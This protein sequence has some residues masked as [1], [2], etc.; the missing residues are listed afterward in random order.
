MVASAA[1]VKMINKLLKRERAKKLPRGSG[2][3]ASSATV[4][5][6]LDVV[7]KHVS[8]DKVTAILNDLSA[9]KGNSSFMTTIKMLIEAWRKRGNSL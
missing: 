7:Q 3:A 4:D 8:S 2:M 1:T 5:K 9:V 6:V